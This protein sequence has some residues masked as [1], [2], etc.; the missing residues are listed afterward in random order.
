M[1]KRHSLKPKLKRRRNFSLYEAMPQ[2]LQHNQDSNQSKTLVC[3]EQKRF[4]NKW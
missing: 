3:P 1:Q 2:L 4:H